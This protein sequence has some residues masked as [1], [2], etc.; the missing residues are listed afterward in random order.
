MADVEA[1][2]QP[3]WFHHQNLAQDDARPA[4]QIRDRCGF[5]AH[6]AYNFFDEVQTRRGRRL[7]GIGEMRDDWIERL[8]VNLVA[9]FVERKMIVPLHTQPDILSQETR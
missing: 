6:P 5:G 4:S 9:R 2:P 7:Q 8:I 3:T 1:V